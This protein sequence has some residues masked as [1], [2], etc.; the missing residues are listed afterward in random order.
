MPTI[1]A[2]D[3][4]TG[5]NKASLY[6]ADGQCLGAV[7][8]PYETL[9]PD[10]GLH[11]QRPTDWWA[12]V[13]QSTRELLAGGDVDP[14]SIECL[15]VSGHSLGCVPLD[16]SG[17][18]LRKSTP[19]WSDKRPGAAQL[20]PFFDRIDP[21]DWYQRTGNGF[22][23]A[24]YT[25]FKI[26][27][28][29]DT[30]PEL[31]AN[32]DKIIGT[33][34]YVNLKLTGRLATDYS[35]ASG[36]GAYNLKDWAYDPELIEASGLSRE[37]FPEIVPSTEILGTLTP[38]AAAELGL[39]QTV[40]VACGGVDN[41]CMALG[42]RNI[43][44][45]R[46]YASLGSSAWIAVSS[47]EPLLDQRA[48]PYV[49]TH[50]I[51]GMFTSA[52]AIFSSG[53]SF[54][55]IRDQMCAD[56]VAQAEEKD[57]DPYELMTALAA[58]SPVGSNGLL[59]N[60]SMAGGSSLEASP[61]IRGALLGIDLGHTRADVVRSAMEGIALNLRIVLDELRGMRSVTNEMTVV[62]GSSQ[63]KLWRSIFADAFDI[64]IVKTN[65]GQ[66]AGSLGAAAVAAVG[67]GLWSDFSKI[68]NVHQIEDVATPSPEN[69]AV[70]ESLLPIFRQSA[71]DQSELGEAV[72]AW[73]SSHGKTL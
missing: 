31:F 19:I 50:V 25:V 44:E 28:L 53:T 9:Y 4:G 3:L 68:D 36:C 27:H 48:K 38:E 24:H 41:S 66:E 16:A 32:V 62:G 51:P 40:K 59:F 5:G 35:Y 20:E 63:S 67:A 18:L 45:G 42:A 26:M 58:E 8:T 49:F 47:E 39:P 64:N 33:K 29:R 34:D 56:L 37:L 14:A 65:V 7:F 30:E 15:A 23:A 22:P 55:W 69:R 43:Q 70:Y 46:V 17:R 1:L 71:A 52:V 73:K 54:R 12:A 61:H 72:H 57:V 21:A 60:P 2:Y 13:V 6:D 10:A 11:E